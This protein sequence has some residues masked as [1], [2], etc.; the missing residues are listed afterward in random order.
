MTEPAR[1]S[2]GAAM[3]GRCGA[4]WLSYE[5]A[6]LADRPCTARDLRNSEKLAFQSAFGSTALVHRAIPKT[7]CRKSCGRAALNLPQA[8]AVP[9]SMARRALLY[10]SQDSRQEDKLSSPHMVAPC[11]S[12]G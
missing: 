4:V 1:R 8:S 11:N 2:L 12:A 10:R 7:S 6:P 9:A 3:S 5:V